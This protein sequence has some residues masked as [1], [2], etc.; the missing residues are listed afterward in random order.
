MFERRR[1]LSPALSR[2]SLGCLLNMLAV[3]PKPTSLRDV[4]FLVQTSLP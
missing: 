2:E 4:L 3:F 1:V